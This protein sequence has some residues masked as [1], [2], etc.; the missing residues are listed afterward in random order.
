[1]NWM[2]YHIL[3]SKT[4]KAFSPDLCNSMASKSII[5]T[6][7]QGWMDWY[8]ITLTKTVIIISD[9]KLGVAKPTLR[10]CHREENKQHNKAFK[11]TVK[12]S[13]LSWKQGT[14]KSHQNPTPPPNN[15]KKPAGICPENFFHTTTRT[16]GHGSLL[17]RPNPARHKGRENT[18][19]SR[20][21][22]PWALQCWAKVS[23]WSSYTTDEDT[24]VRCDLYFNFP[25]ILVWGSCLWRTGP[26]QDPRVG[27]RLAGV[28]QKPP[29]N[30]TYPQ[31]QFRKSFNAS[32]FKQQF[33]RGNSNLH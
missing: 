11:T 31:H 28:S 29:L 4:L 21:K 14:E 22:H 16:A 15:C 20:D 19:G 5:A 27:R 2:M 1:M 32:Y 13:A 33:W 25:C 12:T 23:R 9:R 18:R 3:L 8:K 10:L 6:G 30:N 7:G 17:A 24:A 26:W